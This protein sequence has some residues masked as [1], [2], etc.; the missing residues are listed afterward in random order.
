MG[1]I[2]KKEPKPSEEQKAGKSTLGSSSFCSTSLCSS[3]NRFSLLL[4]ASVAVILGG[5][6]FYAL[7]RP[8]QATLSDVTRSP[9]G[10][11]VGELEDEEADEEPAQSASFIADIGGSSSIQ[12]PSA[13]PAYTQALNQSQA[14]VKMPPRHP[15]SKKTE[16]VQAAP[17]QTEKFVDPQIYDTDDNDNDNIPP[18]LL[19]KG[20]EFYQRV[21]MLEQEIHELRS[22]LAQRER[23]IAQLSRELTE[24]R[25]RPPVIAMEVAAPALEPVAF[26]PRSHTVQRGET[27]SEIA[28][29]YYGTRSAWTK[30]YRANAEKVPD[31]N[32]LL[33]GVV[34]TIPE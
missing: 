28:Q 24:S 10:F 27:L 23:M 1:E 3:S 30:I 32:R 15:P 11:D 4:C 20:P 13:S 19:V 33:V 5:V 31:K 9:L 6:A 34:L 17:E 29:R 8:S 16:N 14:P 21:T 26:K 2:P 25:A 7:T 18:Q 22:V 12:A